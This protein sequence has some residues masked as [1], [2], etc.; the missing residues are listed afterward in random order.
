MEWMCRKLE[1]M[2]RS[3]WSPGTD[4]QAGSSHRFVDRGPVCLTAGLLGLELG[5]R[6]P[7]VAQLPPAPPQR[8]YEL[9]SLPLSAQ[10]HHP[11]LTPHWLPLLT[12]P[13]IPSPLWLLPNGDLCSDL[14]TLLPIAH[15]LNLSIY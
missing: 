9:P 15:W 5:P 13:S 12:Y 3:P 2:Q 10:P 6:K 11:H 4:T 1:A 8:L 7:A 14:S